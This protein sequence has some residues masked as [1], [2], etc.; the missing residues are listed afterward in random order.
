MKSEIAGVNSKCGPPFSAKNSRPATLKVSEK[1]SPLTGLR[2][3]SL[4]SEFGISEV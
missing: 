4:I 1:T 2:F 3:I